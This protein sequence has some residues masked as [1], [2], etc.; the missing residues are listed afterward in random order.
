MRDYSLCP[1]RRHR[2]R[3]AGPSNKGTAVPGTLGRALEQGHGAAENARTGHGI[4]RRRAGRWLRGTAWRSRHGSAQPRQQGTTRDARPGASRSRG[5][6]GP[7]V[8]RKGCGH[9]RRWRSLAH[10]RGEGEARRPRHLQSREGRFQDACVSRCDCVLG[11]KI[12]LLPSAPLAYIYVPSSFQRCMESAAT[13]AVA[14]RHLFRR[15]RASTSS[16]EPAPEVD[17]ECAVRYRELFQRPP[18]RFCCYHHLPTVSGMI[19]SRLRMTA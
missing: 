5:R 14:I 6:S 16:A 17:D 11:A 3:W 9:V 13:P 7:R 19:S 12:P 1:P 2:A 18:T 4:R 10:T 8:R 15:S